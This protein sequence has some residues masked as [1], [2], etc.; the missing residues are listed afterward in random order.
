[1]LSTLAAMRSLADVLTC[2]P[3][4]F[5]S[6]PTIS[7]RQIAYHAEPNGSRRPYRRGANFLRDPLSASTPLN[8]DE[9]GR[10]IRQAEQIELRSKAKGR[11]NGLLGQTGLQVLRVL[12][13]KF[14]NRV[15]GL[16]IPSYRAIMEATGFCR[17]TVAKAIR[18]LEACGIVKAVRRLVRRLVE[19]EDGSSYVGTVQ[20]SNAYSFRLGGLVAIKIDNSRCDVNLDRPRSFPR[21]AASMLALLVGRNRTA[22]AGSTR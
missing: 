17:Q 8:R 11:R 16:C 4:P 1:V 15:S 6:R 22:P 7:D 14:A 20:A 3:E 10:L 5:G 2:K 21:P 13:L 9:R 18:A 12:V 19:R